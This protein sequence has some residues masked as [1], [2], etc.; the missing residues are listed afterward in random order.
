MA[1]IVNV[2]RKSTIIE[3]SESEIN[4]IRQK[5]H[6]L[7]FNFDNC[8][9]IELKEVSNA[10]SPQPQPSPAPKKAPEPQKS[11][12]P[13]E[14]STPQSSSQESAFPYKITP[15]KSGY[16]IL[17]PQ[18]KL[19]AVSSLFHQKKRLKKDDPNDKKISY[20]FAFKSPNI[21]FSVYPN[22][23]PDENHKIEVALKLLSLI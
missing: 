11:S 4:E 2:G 8:Q 22:D 17:I 13:Q 20:F 19:D 3:G 7:G 16:S 6:D 18:S 9:Y 1:Q 23:S 15:I 10:Y 5:L 21:E 14:T 12:A